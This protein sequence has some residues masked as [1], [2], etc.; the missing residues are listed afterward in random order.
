[1]HGTGCVF[2]FVFYSGILWGQKLRLDCFCF[3]VFWGWG[4][5][6]KQVGSRFLVFCGLSQTRVQSQVGTFTQEEGGPGGWVEEGM[7]GWMD[8][9]HKP[10]MMMMI[11]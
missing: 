2:S 6:P 10:A 11:G 5:V 9:I 4:F 1:M 3:Q 8:R 7:D